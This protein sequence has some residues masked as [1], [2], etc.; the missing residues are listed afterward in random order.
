MVTLMYIN[1]PFNVKTN[2]P[3][4]Y[5]LKHTILDQQLADIMVLDT[6]F[7]SLLFILT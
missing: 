5:W 3:A 4:V 1:I 6:Q 2:A 7:H